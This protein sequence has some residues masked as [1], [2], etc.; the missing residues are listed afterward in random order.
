[1]PEKETEAKPKA[2]AKP[3]VPAKPVEAKS[4]PT[5]AE[6][7]AKSKNTNTEAPEKAMSESKTAS[8][9]RGR[10]RKD[11]SKT[12]TKHK[13]QRPENPDVIYAPPPPRPGGPLRRVM[14]DYKNVSD[15]HIE[16][17]NKNYPNG[18][19]NDDLISFVTP[20]GEFIKA[21]EIRTND[22]IYLFKIDN[23]MEVDDEETPDSDGIESDSDIGSF[24]GGSD[25]METAEEEEEEEA[26]NT[27][28]GGD[29]ITGDETEEAGGDEEDF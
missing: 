21:L 22:T 25:D 24:K 2:P 23:N 27:E 12:T 11:P 17:I 7:T 16:L 15:E 4:A 14:K 8:P 6:K 5:K 29:E 1:M 20:K 28:D 19:E 13:V 18:F 3:A 10:P 9:R 26:D